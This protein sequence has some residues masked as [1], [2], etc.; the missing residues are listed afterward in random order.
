MGCAFTKKNHRDL[1]IQSIEH[2]RSID[3]L[4]ESMQSKYDRQIEDIDQEVKSG[5]KRGVN[6]QLLLAKLRKKKIISHYVTQCSA[7]RDQILHKQYALEQLSIGSMQLEA[8]KSTANVFK[9]FTKTNS[10]EKIE[11]LQDSMEEFQDQVMEIDEIINK[12][13]VDFD[14]GE[15][16]QELQEMYNT[17]MD[18]PMEIELQ[19]VGTRTTFP[20]APEHEIY[21]SDKVPLLV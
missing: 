18:T 17:P 15:L 20:N 7:K 5:I 10:V 8:M 4:L 1:M 12:D 9:K 2:L 14:E 21:D 13:N 6:K 11:Q 16:E 3:Q 19:P